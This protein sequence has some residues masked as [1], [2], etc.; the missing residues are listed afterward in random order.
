[1]LEHDTER[2][3][4]RPADAHNLARLV[5]VPAHWLFKQD[6]FARLCKRPDQIRARVGRGQDHGKIDLWVSGHRVEVREGGNR[7]IY[8]GSCFR[9]Q[10]FGPVPAARA[11]GLQTHSVTRRCNCCDMGP[12]HHARSDQDG[13]FR[14][15]VTHDWKTL[16]SLTTA[17][18]HTGIPVVNFFEY[19]YTGSEEAPQRESARE[20]EIASD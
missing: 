11:D 14:P 17:V 1:M 8:S 20:Q 19:R 12:G 7:P 18:S 4:C 3:T 13:H 10:G 2:H 5:R 9:C 15:R 6:M 16:L